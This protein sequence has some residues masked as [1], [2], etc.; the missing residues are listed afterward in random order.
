MATITLRGQ[1]TETFGRLPP[2]GHTAPAFSL[3]NNKLEACS[4]SDFS[5]RRKLIY[6]LPSLDTP[7]CAKSSRKLVEQ[8]QAAKQVDENT[9]VLIIS[10]DLPFAQQRFC[11]QHRLDAITMLSLHRDMAFGREYGLLI[12]D[13][14]LSGLLARAVLVLDEQDTVRYTELVS[15]IGHEPDYAAALAALQHSTAVH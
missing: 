13:G 4:L 14:P 12:T 1:A 7:V 5:G 15:E 11:K 8:L 3:L 6:T 10:A 9:T 2:V